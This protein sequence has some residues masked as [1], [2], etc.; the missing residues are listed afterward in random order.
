MFSDLLPQKYQIKSH[1][2]RCRHL[3]KKDVRW[4]TRFSSSVA[5]SHQRYSKY[6]NYRA[7]TTKY[8]VLIG[9]YRCSI[10]S[11]KL[12]L[13]RVILTTIHLYLLNFWLQITWQSP[14]YFSTPDVTLLLFVQLFPFYQPIPSSVTSLD[15]QMSSVRSQPKSCTR[16]GSQSLYHLA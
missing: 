8:K 12:G 2:P 7:V 4:Q 6:W 3:I 13:N 15:S 1:F 9:C 11:D 10:T 16:L 14:S 5:V